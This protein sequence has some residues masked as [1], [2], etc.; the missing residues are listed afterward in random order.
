[1]LSREQADRQKWRKHM[2]H[3]MKWS[4]FKPEHDPKLTVEEQRLI[5]DHIAR[6]GV[7]R[8]NAFGEQVTP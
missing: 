6:N 8:F 5:A 3:N 1:M 7:R 4:P 2:F